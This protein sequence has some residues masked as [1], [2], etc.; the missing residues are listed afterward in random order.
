MIILL[1][2]QM[3]PAGVPVPSTNWQFWA[4][5][6]YLTLQTI[7]QIM[8]KVQSN[9]T[10]KLASEIKI[11][12]DGL[13]AS[14]VKLAGQAGHAAGIVRG[15]EKEQARAAEVLALADEVAAAKLVVSNEVSAAKLALSNEVAEHLARI[16]AN[17]P[18]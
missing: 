16:K 13:V 8:A 7:V 6:G 1:V 12:T 14:S 9:R 17:V 15:E 5:M 3:L 11:Q 10:E 4:V 18:A 2:A